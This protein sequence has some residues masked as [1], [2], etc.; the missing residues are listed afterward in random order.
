MF[1]AAN[2][3]PKV[4]CQIQS[5]ILQIPGVAAAGSAGTSSCSKVT[6]WPVTFFSASVESRKRKSQ[7]VTIGAKSSEDDDALAGLNIPSKK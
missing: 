6:K 5:L 4:L 7:S 2:P 3:P 1:T